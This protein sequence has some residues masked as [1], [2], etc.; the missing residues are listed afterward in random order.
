M[1]VVNANYEFIMVD[2]GAN[3]RVS[4]GGVFSN[5]EFYN[6]L[7]NN[8]LCIPPPDRLPG[9][10]I[11]QPYVFVA[12]DAFPLMDNLMKPFCRKKWTRE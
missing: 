6:Q 12:D 2:A 1:A 9:C 3:G 8:K 4:D 7:A 5:T 11:E 10:E